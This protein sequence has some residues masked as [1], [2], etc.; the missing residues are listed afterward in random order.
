M[1]FKTVLLTKATH[2]VVL[3]WRDLPKLQTLYS[4]YFEP[5]WERILFADSIFHMSWQNVID[6]INY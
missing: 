3:M 6:E 1:Q 5:L 4:I 2:I